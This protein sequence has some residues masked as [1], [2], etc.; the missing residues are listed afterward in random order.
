MLHKGRCSSP[1]CTPNTRCTVLYRVVLHC[2]EL[3]CQV[4]RSNTDDANQ[5]L[6]LKQAET[7]FALVTEG[8]TLLHTK[9]PSTSDTRL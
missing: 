1:Y 5:S 9:Q 2:K 6:A 7:Q 8:T 4:L 3:H